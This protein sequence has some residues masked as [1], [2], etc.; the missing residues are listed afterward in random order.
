M[1]TF[2]ASDRTRDTG[3]NAD[4]SD[5]GYTRFSVAPGGETRIGPI[6]TYADIEVP[7]FQNTRGYQ[8]TAPFATKVIMS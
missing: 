2:L 7:I 3:N 6:R 5:S 1:L 8:L 4:P